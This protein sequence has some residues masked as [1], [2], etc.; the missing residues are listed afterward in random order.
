MA[1]YRCDNGHFYD[2]EK[3]GSCPHCEARSAATD[4]W[5]AS[6]EKPQPS[7][8]ANDEKTVFGK[9]GVGIAA[10][11]QK[12]HV[13]MATPAAARDEKTVGIFHTKKGMNP[14]TGWLVCMQGAEKGRDFRLHVGRNFIG[15]AIENDIALIDDREISR[16]DHC[17]IIYEPNQG[18]FVL[19]RGEGETKVCG[20]SLGGSVPL[21][22]DERIEMGASVFVFVPFCKEDRKW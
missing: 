11:G 3:H 8:A 21:L 6:I 1:I 20:E 10:E 12:I 16:K 19:L 18:S 2:D 4:Q 15:R 22:G 5:T 7:R 14:V 9:A 13:E 17:S